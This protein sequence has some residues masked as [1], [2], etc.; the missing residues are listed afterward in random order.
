MGSSEGIVKGLGSFLNQNLL[1]PCCY[2]RQQMCIDDDND[3]DD[4]P[5]IQLCKT[6]GTTQ[7]CNSHF[8]LKVDQFFVALASIPDHFSW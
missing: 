6:I 5:L 3:D 8:M 2:Q 1:T 7:P 4:T